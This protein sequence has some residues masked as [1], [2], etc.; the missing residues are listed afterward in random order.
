MRNNSS[1]PTLFIGGLGLRTTE[2]AI[3]T[4][5]GQWGEVLR[6]K[7]I[8]CLNT[9]Q[10]K[11][12]ALVFLYTTSAAEGMLQLSHS[13]EGRP[14]RVEWASKDKISTKA[15]PERT[16]FL[17]G[18]NPDTVSQQ[19]IEGLSRF[20]RVLD[21]RLFRGK[22]EG[23]QAT[24]TFAHESCA[25]HLLASPSP[26]IIAGRRVKV[27][28]FKQSKSI[29]KTPF[30]CDEQ[31]KL[32]L[33][34]SSDQQPSL[35][36]EDS[37]LTAETFQQNSN[38]PDSFQEIT[39]KKEKLFAAVS[40][41]PNNISVSFSDEADVPLYKYYLLEPLLKTDRLFQIFCQNC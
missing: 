37:D 30:G 29:R 3:A 28:P 14:L 27:C 19:V 24:V 8:R 26:V 15:T 25:R 41:F 5:F 7:L 2:Q 20:G 35:D 6:A 23:L 34:S 9:G 16:L 38:I 13:L 36:S 21:C 31:K 32:A 22:T 18:L 17:S 33:I 11:G 4:Y 12:C 1:A 39:P 10:S 40:L